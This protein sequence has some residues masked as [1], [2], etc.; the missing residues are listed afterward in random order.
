MDDMIDVVEATFY[1]Y[2]DMGMML[3]IQVGDES[4]LLSRSQAVDVASVLMSWIG[5]DDA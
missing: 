3:E 2:G 4:I 5:S 1:N